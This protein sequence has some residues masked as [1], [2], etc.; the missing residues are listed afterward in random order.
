MQNYSLLRKAGQCGRPIL[1]KR[2]MSATLTELLLA[3]EYILDQGNDQVVLCERGIRTFADH[4]RNTLDISA[5]PAIKRISHLP[6][7]VDPSHAAGM[8]DK[9]IPL[10]KAAVAGGADGLLVEVHDRPDTARSDGNQALFPEQFE[11]L[12]A[13]VRLLASVLDKAAP[14]LS[15]S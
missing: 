6:I 11:E 4:T 10:S 9:V 1:L 2:G 5:I 13:S 15:R 14:T 8:R 12:C 7:I 3:A